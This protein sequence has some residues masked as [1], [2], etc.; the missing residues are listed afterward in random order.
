MHGIFIEQ[1][2]F[3]W[4]LQEMQF[5]GRRVFLSF[6]DPERDVLGEI[7][8]EV[9]IFSEGVRPSEISSLKEIFHRIPLASVYK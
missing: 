7:F 5:L 3:F 6:I 8:P 4:Q 9:M 1:K 2:L